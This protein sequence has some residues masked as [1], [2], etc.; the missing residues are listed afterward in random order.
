MK[1]NV[2]YRKQFYVFS[3]A[4]N[5]LYIQYLRIVQFLCL[6]EVFKRQ[7]KYTKLIILKSIVG[8]PFTRHLPLK[9]CKRFKTEVNIIRK[10][11]II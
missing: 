2:K 10:K 9:T 4:I 1:E 8:L 11:N 7:I 6:L 3:N 5:V